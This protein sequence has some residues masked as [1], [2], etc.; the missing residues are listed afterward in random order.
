MKKLTLTLAM[1]LVIAATGCGDSNAPI[2]TYVARANSSGVTPTPNLFKLNEAT[3]TT[4]A[5]TIP[6]PDTAYYVSANAS[7][8]E[9]TY[10]RDG[11]SGYD[12]F[13]MGTD[14]VEKQLTTG[15][16]ACESVFSPD[17]KTMAFVSCASGDCLIMTMNVDG[18][19]QNAL[20]TPPAGTAESF[21][22][23]FSP[24]GKSVVF[25]AFTN[26]GPSAA[27]RHLS[28]PHMSG[29]ISPWLAQGPVKAKKAH[30]AAAGTG[31]TQDGWYVMGLS[32]TAPTFAY[33]P[34]SWWGPAMFTGDGSKLLL[35]DYDGTD[36]NIFTVNLDG[37]GL[38]QLTTS[39]DTDNFSPVPYKNLIMFNR[40]NSTNSSWDIYAMD[41]T[42]ANQTLIH[43]TADTWE[44]LLD[45]YWSGN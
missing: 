35:T 8:T 30:P 2:L 39:T 42:G 33:A 34:N 19:N 22:P 4:T 14:G 12:I 40:Y 17:N 16:D 7:A 28:M 3:Q 15:A 29:R 18:S 26:S 20:Y 25:Y 5:V 13:V 6:I 43:S 32:D 36:Y 27:Q 24:N 21:Y 9:V 31:I 23:E 44:S 11:S 10:C 38:M 37:T 41:Q 45:S 1:A